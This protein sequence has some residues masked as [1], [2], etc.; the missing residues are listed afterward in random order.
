MLRDF[1]YPSMQLQTSLARMPL[2]EGI[3]GVFPFKPFKS[4]TFYRYFGSSS[5][6]LKAERAEGGPP[7]HKWVYLHS[8]VLMV[9]FK[10]QPFLTHPL[11]QVLLLPK[12]AQASLAMQS[13]SGV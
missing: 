5:E 10:K 3:T 4:N 11:I 7:M 12:M 13:L 6:S 8:I 9:G 2:Q 1:L